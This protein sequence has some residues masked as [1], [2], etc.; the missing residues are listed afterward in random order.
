MFNCCFTDPSSSA[1]ARLV[2]GSKPQEGRIEVGLNFNGV[3]VW[4]TVCNDEWSTEEAQVVCR[5]LGLPY[6]AAQVS[7][8]GHFGE[9]VGPIWMDDVSCI[10][11]ENNLWECGHLEWGNNDCEHL[12]DAGVICEY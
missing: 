4:G 1:L 8:E 12:E 3:L 9:G 11:S 10:G 5:Q 7:D 6:T 2:N